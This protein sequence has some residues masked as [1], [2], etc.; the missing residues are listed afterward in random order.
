MLLQDK[1]AHK[2]NVK[3]QNAII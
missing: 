3:H 2:E 1:E